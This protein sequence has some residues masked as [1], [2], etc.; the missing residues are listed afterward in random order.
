[1]AFSAPSP[2]PHVHGQPQ[3][4]QVAYY[5]LFGRAASGSNVK[6][7]FS[8][9]HFPGLG[10]DVPV[11]AGGAC[12][13]AVGGLQPN[14]DY[15]FA[16]AAYSSHGKLLGKG[17]GQ[18]SVVFRTTFDLPLLMAWAYCCQVSK[19]GRLFLCVC[20]CVLS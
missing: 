7:R 12:T 2:P 5:R 11:E 10:V 3:A 8:D 9:K 14:Q 15:V 4:Q 13:L 19:K 20:V 18:T 17:I 6:V 16:V 1:M